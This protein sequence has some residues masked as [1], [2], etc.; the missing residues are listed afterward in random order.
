MSTTAAAAATAARLG[1]DM[2]CPNSN[3]WSPL[4]VKFH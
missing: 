2:T 3:N 4:S 1:L